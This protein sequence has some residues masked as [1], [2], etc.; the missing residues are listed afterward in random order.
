MKRRG[1]EGE[2]TNLDKHVKGESDLN[3]IVTEHECLELKWLSIF[4]ESSNE[5]EREPVGD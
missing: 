2:R 5:Y 3:Q 1:G 4:H